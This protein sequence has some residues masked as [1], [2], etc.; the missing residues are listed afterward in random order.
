MYVRD[1][2]IVMVHYI[3]NYM[4][5]NNAQLDISTSTVHPRKLRRKLRSASNKIVQLYNSTHGIITFH[6][7]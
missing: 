5:G 2:S 3:G 6:R 1:D 4:S 7:I